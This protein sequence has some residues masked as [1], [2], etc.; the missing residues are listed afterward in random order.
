MVKRTCKPSCTFASRHFLQNACE[1]MK[2]PAS[3]QIR[4]L[5]DLAQNLTGRSSSGIKAEVFPRSLFWR[6]KAQNLGPLCTEYT[7]SYQINPWL[8]QLSD[9]GSPSPPTLLS[10][11]YDQDKFRF[12]HLCTFPYPFISVPDNITHTELLSAMHL[13]KMQE[14]C[15]EKAKLNRTVWHME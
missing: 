6:D 11:L 1:P 14:F 15:W 9:N 13:L 7:C 10:C 12:S 3:N 8:R 5:V 4:P 2:L